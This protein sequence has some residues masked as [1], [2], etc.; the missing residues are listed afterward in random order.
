MDIQLSNIYIIDTKKYSHLYDYIYGIFVTIMRVYFTLGYT[1]MGST[2]PYS[3]PSTQRV[4]ILASDIPVG[5]EIIPYLPSYQVK[6]FGF[7]F[8]ISI[9]ILMTYQ[10]ND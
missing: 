7:G 3:Y 10:P 4:E 8:Q 9:A 5:S 2:H 6:P 1:G